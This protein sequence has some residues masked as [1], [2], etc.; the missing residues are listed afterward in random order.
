MWG[1]VVLLRYLILSKFFKMY[2]N[3]LFKMEERKKKAE[4][5]LF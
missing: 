4:A 1:A 5:S 3:G 2:I